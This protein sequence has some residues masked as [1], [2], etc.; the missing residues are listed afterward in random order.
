MTDSYICVWRKFSPMSWN[1][2]PKLE[3]SPYIVIWTSLPHLFWPTEGEKNYYKSRYQWWLNL[4]IVKLIS[5]QA[6]QI[7][8]LTFNPKYILYVPL[9]WF[10]IFALKFTVVVQSLPFCWELHMQHWLYYNIVDEQSSALCK[11]RSDKMEVEST[12]MNISDL[13]A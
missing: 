1:I 3:F 10:L 11:M 5:H 12:N 4:T 13:P 9:L 7:P 8:N 6:V 2:W